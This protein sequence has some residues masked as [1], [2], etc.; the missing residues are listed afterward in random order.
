MPAT[1]TRVPNTISKWSRAP[2]GTSRC[3]AFVHT[4]A[5]LCPHYVHE[6]V[7]EWTESRVEKT[8]ANAV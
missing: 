8:D 3:F 2:N 5:F 6:A 7:A 1:G 4:R